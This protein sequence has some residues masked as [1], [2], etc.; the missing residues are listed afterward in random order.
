MRTDA[1][2]LDSQLSLQREADEVEQD[3]DLPRLLRGLGEPVRV[4]SAALGVMVHRD[5]DVTVVCSELT[6]KEVAELGARIALHRR[7][8]SVL[9]RN[10]FGEWN[11]DPGYPDGLYLGIRYRSGSGDWNIDVWFVDEP[12][13]QPDLQHLESLLPRI[14]ESARCS[15]LR[16]KA[17]LAPSSE[18]GRTFNG[19]DVYTAVLDSGVTDV[20]GFEKWLRER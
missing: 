16:I 2:L 15:I 7:V 18:Y 14:D 20:R 8:R 9:F 4:G 5:L 10:D 6:V 3:L 11:S 1:S 19:F 13:R 12:Q 17:T